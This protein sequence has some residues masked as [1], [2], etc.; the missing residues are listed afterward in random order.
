MSE[1]IKV[2]DLV[3]VIKT[4]PCCGRTDTLGLTF[5][6]T[7]IDTKPG[8]CTQCVTTRPAGTVVA[9]TPD[10]HRIHL[11]RLKRIPPLAEL[12]GGRTQEDI[13]EPA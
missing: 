12:E 10:T 8:A 9:A 6:V 4:A 1:P 11:Y 2:G 3:M 7:A 5:H 13:R